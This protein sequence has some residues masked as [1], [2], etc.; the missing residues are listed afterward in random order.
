MEESY[1]RSA[2]ADRLVVLPCCGD[3]TDLN[4]LDYGNWPVAFAR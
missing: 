3:T 4:D 1:E 2:F